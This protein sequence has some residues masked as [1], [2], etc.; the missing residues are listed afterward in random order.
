MTGGMLGVTMASHC[1][2]CFCFVL[3]FPLSVMLGVALGIMLG[4]TVGVAPRRLLHVV[5]NIA[6]GV[7]LG[8]A[9]LLSSH[10]VKC[11][12]Y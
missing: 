4:L 2:L 3:G 5:V 9:L 11:W 8:M 12:V 10:F 1:V 7:V 6:L